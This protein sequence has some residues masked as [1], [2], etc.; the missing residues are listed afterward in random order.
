[1]IRCCIVVALNVVLVRLNQYGFC[2]TGYLTSGIKGFNVIIHSHVH[3]ILEPGTPSDYAI[4]GGIFMVSVPLLVGIGAL[5]LNSI[6][7]LAQWS[8]HGPLYLGIVA[9]GISISSSAAI[10]CL[11]R[12]RKPKG[13][14]ATNWKQTLRLWSLE[15]GMRIISLIMAICQLIGT[16]ILMLLIGMHVFGVKMPPLA[17]LQHMLFHS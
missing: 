4:A 8:T 13:T 17:A 12:S 15:L 16:G 2:V 1:M 10:Y 7:Q 3:H 9:C 6:S 14:A 5:G 11:N